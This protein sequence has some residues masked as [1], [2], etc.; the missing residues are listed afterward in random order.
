MRRRPTCIFLW[1]TRH[2]PRSRNTKKISASLALFPEKDRRTFAGYH[3]RRKAEDALWTQIRQHNEKLASS[4]ES[5]LGLFRGADPVAIE[6]SMIHLLIGVSRR[7]LQHDGSTSIFEG[8]WF[9]H[10]RYSSWP[11]ILTTKPPML[12]LIELNSLENRQFSTGVY[13]SLK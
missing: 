11:R 13:D 9:C 7:D 3:S 2:A 12:A 8:F 1:K 5:M 4:I 6:V 10:H